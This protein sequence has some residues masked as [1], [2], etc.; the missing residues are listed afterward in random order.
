MSKKTS[1]A[2]AIAAVFGAAAFPAAAGRIIEFNNTTNAVYVTSNTQAWDNY[3]TTCVN[4]T[5]TPGSVDPGSGCGPSKPTPDDAL[6]FW[7][8]TAGPTQRSART[9]RS[10]CSGPRKPIARRSKLFGC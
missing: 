7:V 8:E 10:T 2:I 5:Q 6:F 1:I 3:A 4:A 9:Q